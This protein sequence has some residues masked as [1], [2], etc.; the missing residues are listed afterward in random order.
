MLCLVLFWVNI[1]SRTRMLFQWNPSGTRHTFV[2]QRQFIVFW[3]PTE[4]RQKHF[5]KKKK[6]TPDVF[7]EKEPDQWKKN[8]I[9][10]FSEPCG[11]NAKFSPFIY[12]RSFWVAQCYSWGSFPKGQRT[13]FQKETCMHGTWEW[14]HG[15]ECSQRKTGQSASSSIPWPGLQT[16]SVLVCWLSFFRARRHAYMYLTCGQVLKIVWVGNLFLFRKTEQ[17]KNNNN[18]TCASITSWIVFRIFML[19]NVISPLPLGT[20]PT[21]LSA[22]SPFNQEGDA[23]PTP[24]NTATWSPWQMVLFK[25]G[26]PH[27][28]CCIPRCQ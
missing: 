16:D 2:M 5:Q 12:W 3:W 7:Y 15:A 18:K 20:T 19:I 17:K 26:S 4:K 1:Y 11:G 9:F 14:C 25:P 21:H 24:L 13:C 6:S 23:V 22:T 28:T 27:L 8:N 10:F